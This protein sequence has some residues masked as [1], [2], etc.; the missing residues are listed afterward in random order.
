[1]DLRVPVIEIAG[2]VRCT[3]GECFIGRIFVPASAHNHSGPMRPEEWMNGHPAFF[4]F[5]P[6]NAKIPILIS[7][8]EILWLSVE[9]KADKGDLPDDVPVPQRRVQ[10]Q[11]EGY[12]LEG[13]LV[14]DLPEFQ[15]RVL[16]LLNGPEEFVTLR[17]DLHHYL[18]PKRR[19]IRVME[20]QEG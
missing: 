3:D 12:R 2:Q 14:L 9:E 18:V 10:L 13:T 11:L 4:P 17:K 15:V 1:M 19:I 5:L 7:K 20:I 16:D 8:S 6:E